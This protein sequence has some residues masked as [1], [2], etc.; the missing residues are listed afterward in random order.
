MK[1]G[2]TDIQYN[3]LLTVLQEQGETPSAEPEKGTSDKQS[4]GQGYPS[5]GKW[6]SGVTRGPGNQVGVTKWADVVGSKLTRGKANPLKEQGN[7][8]GSFEELPFDPKRPTAKRFIVNKTKRDDFYVLDTPPS[9]LSSKRNIILPKEVNGIKT[10][11]TFWHHPIKNPFWGNMANTKYNDLVPTQEMLI[12]ALPEGSLRSF[13]VG[14][15]QYTSSMERTQDKPLMI[16][17][18]WYYD[19]NNQPYKEPN[20]IPNELKE[21]TFWEKFIYSD[22]GISTELLWIGAAIIVGIMTEGIGAAAIGEAAMSAEAFTLLGRRVT[23]SALT[24]YFAEAGV[25]TA[26]GLLAKSDGKNLSGDIDIAFGVL[27]PIIHEFGIINRMNIGKVTKESVDELAQKIIGK[28][29]TELLDLFGRAEAQGG[30]S[31]AAKELFVKASNCSRKVW[32]ET[33]KEAIK[34]AANILKSKGLNIQSSLSDFLMKVGD[35]I[36]KKWLLRFSFVLLHDITLLESL[37]KLLTVS[38]QKDRKEIFNLA[39][40][41]YEKALLEGKENEYLN[42]VEEIVNNSKDTTKTLENAKQI[43]EIKEVKGN[44]PISDELM[45]KMQDSIKNL[46]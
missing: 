41:N 23:I 31:D 20:Q 13:T 6:E 15:V 40:L 39:V 46:K 1:L 9:N 17:F 8:Q 44:P 34:M 29:E 24:K 21:R 35:G 32:T 43:F 22:G 27:L 12:E 36:H 42:N 25:F 19:K 26:K 3:S 14:G 38:G 33:S 10:T 5:V 45:I 4:G 11:A 37:K 30:L 7:V 16:S 28:N 2:L 18:K